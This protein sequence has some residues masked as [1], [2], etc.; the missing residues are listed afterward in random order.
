MRLVRYAAP[1]KIEIITAE[2]PQVSG[3]DDVLVR[4]AYAG[5]CDDDIPLYTMDTVNWPLPSAIAGH[6]FSGTVEA[7]GENARKNG[8]CEGDRVS[9][10][11]WLFCGTCH[12]CKGGME[13]HCMNIKCTSV[14][15]DYALLHQKQLCRLPDEVSLEGG[16]LL[17]PVTYCLYNSLYRQNSSAPKVMIFGVNTMSL[18]MLQLAKKQGAV[19]VDIAENDTEKGRLAL[20]LGADHVVPAEPAQIAANAMDYT[21]QYGYD[22]V[23]E[24]S[25]NPDLLP[26]AAQI[27][28]RRG[29]ILYSYMYDLT[30][31]NDLS[32]M[33]LYMKEAV[34]RPF[35]LAPYMLEAAASVMRTLDLKPL[36]SQVYPLEEIRD[37]FCAHLSQKNIKILIKMA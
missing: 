22:M 7:L 3:P 29:S 6:E 15:A 10:Q 26:C 30:T 12:Y 8:F 34:L 32:L 4:I 24:M 25:R 27:L 33:E 31:T 11:A 19:L 21:L 37:A 20:R 9:G 5:I 28:A 18:I 13:N 1:R 17:D 14:F 2:K 16:A 23:Y 36:I 35:F